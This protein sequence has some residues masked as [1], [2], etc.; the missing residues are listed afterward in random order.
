MRYRGTCL[1][2]FLSGRVMRRE[3][4]PRDFR[5]P[6]TNAVRVAPRATPSRQLTPGAGRVLV[7]PADDGATRLLSADCRSLPTPAGQGRRAVD[8][9]GHQ[10]HI[11]SCGISARMERPKRRVSAGRRALTLA[12]GLLLFGAATAIAVQPKPGVLYK[13]HEP[14]CTA[15]AGLSCMFEFLV[16]RNGRTMRF[17]SKHNVIGG[18]ACRG[19]GGEAILGPYTKP[20]HGQPVPLLKIRTNGSFHGTQSFGSGQAKGKVV[21]TGRF[22]GTGSTA[23]LKFTLDPGP[24]ACVNGPVKLRSG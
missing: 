16:S 3:S 6:R 4:I 17:A 2:P 7:A 14:D 23:T 21:A 18:W 12:A 24:H 11:A 8:S 19:G 10:S 22:T 20:E 15:Q 9:A 13:G 1:R 5:Y